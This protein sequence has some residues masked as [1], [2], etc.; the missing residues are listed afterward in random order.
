MPTIE[1]SETAPRMDTTDPTRIT[2]DPVR[3]DDFEELVSV[4]IEAM[5]ESLERVGRFDV[6][7][8]RERL[9]EGFAPECTRHILVDGHRVGFVTV[10]PRTS[11][12]YLEHFYIRPEYQGRGIGSWVIGAVFKEADQVGLPLRVGALRGSNSNRFYSRHGFVRA[13]ETEW[14]IYYLRLPD[15]HIKGGDQ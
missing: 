6:Q 15:A 8:A 14:D 12:L 13:E 3:L 1:R 4:R 11:E 10:K 5:R 7:R 2:L 9:L